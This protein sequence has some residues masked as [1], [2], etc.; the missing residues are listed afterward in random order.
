MSYIV[1]FSTT[2]NA[3]ATVSP[4][5]GSFTH[6]SDAPTSFCRPVTTSIPKVPA[7][8]ATTPSAVAYLATRRMHPPQNDCRYSALSGAD[9]SRT[10]AGAKPR[11]SEEKRVNG[12]SG[13]AFLDE[14]AASKL[15]K[16]LLQ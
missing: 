12:L 9:I 13:S 11:T 16:C 10:R 4:A 2:T 7:H 8:I 6:A 3:E 1:G 14:G 15:R 5:A